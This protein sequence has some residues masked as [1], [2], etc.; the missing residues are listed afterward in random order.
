MPKHTA[1]ATSLSPTDATIVLSFVK[2]GLTRDIPMQIFSSRWLE[3]CFPCAAG[4]AGESVISCLAENTNCSEG[5]SNSL[6][7]QLP[8]V[9]REPDASGL[10]LLLGVCYPTIRCSLEASSSGSND[11]PG[12]S[13]IHS[14]CSC[15]LL[16]IVDSREPSFWTLVPR[17]M[18]CEP[19]NLIFV[20]WSLRRTQNIGIVFGNALTSCISVK[21][22]TLPLEAG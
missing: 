20:D 2:R 6:Q 18:Q 22:F 9:T 12:F 1:R 21:F 3:L 15:F 14:S 19:Q 17:Y 16:V 13:W 8:S 7:M 11:G 10:F 5:S 4:T